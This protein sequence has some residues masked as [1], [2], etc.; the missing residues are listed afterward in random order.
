MPRQHTW[1][2][3]AY[4]HHQV[5]QVLAEVGEAGRPKD[6]RQALHVCPSWQPHGQLD[7]H[8]VTSANKLAPPQH[9]V[10]PPKTWT[11]AAVTLPR[12]A[13][14]IFQQLCQRSQPSA[15]ERVRLALALHAWF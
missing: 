15:E 1:P 14:Y 2:V 11:A 5:A 8:M 12:S 7:L 3:R 4:L 10:T 9:L 6:A 13:V